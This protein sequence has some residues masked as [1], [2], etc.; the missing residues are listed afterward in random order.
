[1]TLRTL[2]EL[3]SAPDTPLVQERSVNRDQVQAWLAAAHEKYEDGLRAANSASTRM[4]ATYDAVLFCALAVLAAQSL[5][6]SG[7]PGHH[8]VALEAAGSTMALKQS[9]FDEVLA[10][11]DWRNRKYRAAFTASA[12]D[13]LDGLDIARRFAEHTATCFAAKSPSC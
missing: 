10:L 3:R 5:R 6:V 4:D 2:A 9:F 13:V 11:R 7:R 8:E 1:M 12:Q